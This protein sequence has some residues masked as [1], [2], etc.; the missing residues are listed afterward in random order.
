MNYH[1]ISFTQSGFLLA[2]RIK[3]LL[4]SQK[5]KKEEMSLSFCSK[6]VEVEDGSDDCKKV[7]LDD[8]VKAYF[9]SGNCLIFTGSCGIAVRS[10]APYLQSKKSDPAVLAVD[11]KGKFVIPLLSGHIG[12]ANEAA[13]KLAQLLGAQTVITTASDVN[14]LPA[15]DEFAARNNLLI[16]DM[17]LAKEFASL[18]LEHSRQ[19]STSLSLKKDTPLPRFSL[20]VYIK[21]Y[22]LNL[23]PRCLILGL[24]CKKGKD[25]DELESFV[26]A[27]FTEHNLDLR[28]LKKIVSIDLKQDEKAL[29]RLAQT[30]SLTFETFS[31]AQLNAIDH[32]VSH[33]DF[34]SSV[35]G[36]D[37]VCER[38]V[39]AGGADEIL[40]SK[41]AFNGMTLSVGIQKVSLEIPEEFKVFFVEDA[42]KHR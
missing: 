34:V 23:I 20:S 26:R 6:S 21:K 39:Y 13:R 32:E 41:R 25:P 12:G 35:T 37:N 40:I 31:S 2:K 5:E 15:I 29:V 9:R 4:T 36:T 10:I 22:I 3:L 1:I 33:S 19:A 14:C 24:G 28:A 16:N 30:L 17:S 18:F 42:D 8:W 27:V 7:K 38:A 11:E